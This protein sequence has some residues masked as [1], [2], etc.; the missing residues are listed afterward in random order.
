MD[1]EILRPFTWDNI[2]DNLSRF[3]S[4]VERGGQQQQQN[5]W[6]YS[7]NHGENTVKAAM[8]AMLAYGLG[9]LGA[10]GEGGSMGGGGSSGGALGTF[11][12]NALGNVGKLFGGLGGGQQQQQQPMLYIPPQQQPQE[13]EQPWQPMQFQN[14]S[15]TPYL[16]NVANTG[17]LRQ[18]QLGSPLQQPV[19]GKSYFFSQ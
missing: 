18:P 4:A 5:S 14:A 8:I 12:G 10:G 6:R 13:K 1:S 11:G 3:G 2:H 19:F 7:D 16:N 15:F 17:M 9:G